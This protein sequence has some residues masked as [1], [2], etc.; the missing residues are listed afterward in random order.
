MICSAI[1]LS[2]GC[3]KKSS[4]EKETE[5]STTTNNSSP[6][7]PTYSYQILNTWPHDTNAF[8]QGLVFLDGDLLEST[9]LNGQS[10][11]RRVE[12]KTGR[13]LKKVDVPEQYFAEGLAVLN[14]KAYQLTWQNHK[15][16]VYDLETFRLEKEFTYDGEGWGLTTDGQSL[17]MSDGT[18]NL[19]F[20]NPT[21]FTVTKT[22]AVSY[23]GQSLINLNELEFVKGEIFANIW[24]T[25]YVVRIDPN[26][27][28]VLGLINFN[29]I[30][31]PADYHPRI[32]VMNGIAYDPK[33]DRLFVTGKNWPKLF[34]VRLNP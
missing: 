31:N 26:S 13:I 33:G 15:G 14:G 30:L 1:I 2:T 4:S 23:N 32:D 8:T 27:G 28:K 21:N 20:L 25:F 17:I 18:Q 16:F 11:L 34:E 9:G 24:Q 22:I 29:G 19:R 12:L 10:S 7:V 3:A 5:L 6:L